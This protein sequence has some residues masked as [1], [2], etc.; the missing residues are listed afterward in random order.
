MGLRLTVRRRGWQ[1]HVQKVA[2]SMPG[3]IPVVKGNGYG[4]GRDVLIPIAA[5]LSAQIAVGTV[6]EARRRSG[7]S[8]ADR[9][10]A[11]ISHRFRPRCRRMPCSPSAASPTFTRCAIMAGPVGSR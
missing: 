8:H 5:G 11:A 9:A 7:R 4:F 10:D 1:E 2:A 6:Y 3:L